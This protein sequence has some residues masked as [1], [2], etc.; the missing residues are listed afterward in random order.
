MMDQATAEHWHR[1]RRRLALYRY[2]MDTTIRVLH[3]G[4][5]FGDLRL[6][7][8]A[9]PVSSNLTPAV[10]AARVDLAKLLQHLE[11]FW[12][13]YRE[14]PAPHKSNSYTKYLRLPEPYPK[15]QRGMLDQCFRVLH[16]RRHDPDK[17]TL[18]RLDALICGVSPPPGMEGFRERYAH[19]FRGDGTPLPSA[20]QR[21]EDYMPP[22]GI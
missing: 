10:D 6:A 4:G 13:A 8:E 11:A 14:L 1:H 16:E 19:L 20:H 15:L 22:G 7:L 3:G 5:N 18:A 2:A 17:T 21:R 9:E 12:A